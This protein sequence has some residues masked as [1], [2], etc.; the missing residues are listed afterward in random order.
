[1]GESPDKKRPRV[2]EAKYPFVDADAWMNT[3]A[4]VDKGVIRVVQDDVNGSR[5]LIDYQARPPTE[6]F[7]LSIP[8]AVSAQCHSAQYSAV[9]HSPLRPRMDCTE[10]TE[11]KIDSLLYFSSRE[12]INNYIAMRESI[13]DEVMHPYFHSKLYREAQQWDVVANACRRDPSLYKLNDFLVAQTY[14]LMSEYRID[15]L[16][17]SWERNN[18][19]DIVGSIVKCVA[20][21]DAKGDCLIPFKGLICSSWTAGILFRLAQLFYRISIVKSLICAKWDDTCFI[22]CQGKRE[23]SKLVDKSFRLLKKL[24]DESPSRETNCEW[25]YSVPPVCF[26]DANF[27]DWIKRINAQLMHAKGQQGSCSIEKFASLFRIKKYLFP[28]SRQRLIGFY[29]GSF[30]PV[31]E[32]H[33]ALAKYAVEHLQV[34][35]VWFIPNSDGNDDKSVISLT[36][37]VALLQRRSAEVGMEWMRVMEPPKSTKRWESKAEIAIEKTSEI[38]TESR[39]YG[40]PVLLLGEDSWNQAVMGSSRDKTT[41]HFIGIAKLSGVQIFVFPRTGTEIGILS[42]PKPIRSIFSV[43]KDY[44]DPVEGL[45]SSQI[46]DLF[47]KDKK[48]EI[49]ANLV[50]PSVMEYIC[51]RKL[52]A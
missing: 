3:L 27:T 32:N 10:S 4:A 5:S 47:L 17:W 35:Q 36:E 46:R 41:R 45:S 15:R 7:S 44:R 22:F 51:M 49:S 24:Y 14:T 16:P 39:D 23:S 18:R 38:F 12:S 40:T 25:G 50:H 1:M 19:R 13:P 34:E 43:A 11:S 9:A 26:K 52:F 31:H 21:L 2:E 8:N 28:E 30:S 33:V 42:P 48:E 29:F 20:E 6:W 37:R